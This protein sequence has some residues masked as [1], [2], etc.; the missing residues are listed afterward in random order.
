M[1]TAV[2]LAGSEREV[3]FC[4]ADRI[5]SST[6]RPYVSTDVIGAQIGGAVKNVIAIACGIAEGR[7]FGDNARAALIARG[8]AEVTR[9][10]VAKGGRA[11]TMRGLSGLGDLAATCT[12]TQSRNYMLGVGL[13][14]NR[15]LQEILAANRSV[16]EGVHTAAA[17]TILAESQGVDM[18]ISRAVDGIL[19]RGESLDEAI[20]ELLSRPVRMEVE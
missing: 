1:P 5:G 16:A 8:L 10:C 15:P 19:N 17:V 14:Q 11:E 6:F 20:E 12:S 3:T 18:P 2:T 9:L 4:L 7:G 13:G